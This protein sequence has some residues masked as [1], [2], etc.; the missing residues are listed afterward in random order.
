MN[1]NDLHACVEMLCRLTE[2]EFGT[3]LRAAF[4]RLPV[5]YQDRVAWDA[6]SASWSAANPPPAVVLDYDP[7]DLA[8]EVQRVVEN[9]VGHV[10]AV[11]VEKIEAAV[12]EVKREAAP[13]VDLPDILTRDWTNDFEEAVGTDERGEMV[14]NGVAVSVEGS[15]PILTVFGADQFPCLDEDDPAEV[16]RFIQDMNA[17]VDAVTAVPRMLRALTRV[18]AWVTEDGQNFPL[19]L[20]SDVAGIL[21]DLRLKPPSVVAV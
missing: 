19:P 10:H 9:H 2:D 11:L 21:R 13:A 5:T 18:Q 8:A 6:L 17:V 15:A 4:A 16:S 3:V 14:G 12:A 1:T 7:A 20:L